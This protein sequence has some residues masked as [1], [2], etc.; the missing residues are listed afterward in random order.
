MNI[1]N[2]LRM[3]AIRR[4]GFFCNKNRGS[5]SGFTLLELMIAVAI[6]AIALVAVY[7]SQSQS[8]SMGIHS[9]FLTTASLLAKDKMIDI[10]A[11]GAKNFMS[12][13]GDFGEDFPD[14]T[15][16]YDITDTELELVKK[17]EVTV[18]NTRLTLNNTYTL[19]LYSVFFK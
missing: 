5:S 7:Q 6:L 12:D 19:I 15:W 17:I 9:K 11:Y 4:R 14:Y 2:G 10:E 18:T 3:T 16:K 8:L 1:I 13:G